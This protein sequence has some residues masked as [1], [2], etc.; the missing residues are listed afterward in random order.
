MTDVDD[1]IKVVAIVIGTAAHT[2]W[3]RGS[4]RAQG[5]NR[6]REDGWAYLPSSILALF[7]D[8]RLGIQGNTKA[9]RVQA[10]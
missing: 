4:P 7:G 9:N 6:C 5:R 2:L 10:K 8:F 1:A 3:A